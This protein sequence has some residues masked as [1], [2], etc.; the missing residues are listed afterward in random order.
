MHYIC[1][2]LG[3]GCSIR[4]G[5]WNSRRRDDNRSK[6]EFDGRARLY[7]KRKFGRPPGKKEKVVT[8]SRRVKSMMTAFQI[9]L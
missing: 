2:D 5:G 4:F 3:G 8:H 1:A 9:T 7:G 6:Q